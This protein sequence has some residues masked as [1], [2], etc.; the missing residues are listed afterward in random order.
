[1]TKSL[2]IL[3]SIVALS[4]CARSITINDIKTALPAS[5]S[6]QEVGK[7]ILAAGQSQQWLMAPAGPGQIDGRLLVRDHQIAV[8]IN[9]SDTEYTISYISSQNMM[10]KDG[11]IHRNYNRWVNNLNKQILLTLPIKSTTPS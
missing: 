3:I 8:R 5:Y 9:Y 11:K 1:M 10:A 2:L 4:G 7:V 6:T